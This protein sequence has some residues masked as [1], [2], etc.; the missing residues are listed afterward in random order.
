[1]GYNN[2]RNSAD[3]KLAALQAR[4]VKYKNRGEWI[5]IQGTWRGGRSFN[6]SVNA[7]SG[8]YK[9]FKTGETGSWPD[10]C[11]KLGMDPGTYSP[12]EKAE[13]AARKAE[14]DAQVAADK[15]RRERR[16]RE[17]MDPES[18][19]CRGLGR[20]LSALSGTMAAHFLTAAFDDEEYRR[21]K[22]GRRP[23]DYSRHLTPDEYRAGVNYL[24]SRGAL[25]FAAAAGALIGKGTAKA[26][27]GEG[28]ASPWEIRWPIENDVTDDVTGVQR[29]WARGH[30]G[31]KML[32]PKT[33]GLLVKRQNGGD[34]SGP[35]IIGEGMMTLRA[36]WLTFPDHHCWVRYDA[37]NMKAIAPDVIKGLAAKVIW[38]LVDNDLP[39]AEHP[40]RGETGQKASQALAEAIM[41]ARPDISVKLA[42]SPVPG[43]DWDD[44]ERR[45]KDEPAGVFQS[46]FLSALRDPQ[47][48]QPSGKPDDNDQAEPAAST[49]AEIIKPFE[50]FRQKPAEAV[51]LEPLETMTRAKAINGQ[52]R[53]VFAAITHLA[54]SEPESRKPAII[55][56]SVGT[57][58]TR[59]MNRAVAYHIGQGQ[60]AFLIATPRIEDRDAIAKDIFE[61]SG[62]KPHIH[63]ARNA[64]NCQKIKEVGELY[65]KHR[66]P[67]AWECQACPHGKADLKT[68]TEDRRCGYVKSLDA[69]L[70]ALGVI[71]THQAIQEDSKLFKKAIEY[72]THTAF[73]DRVVIL[74]EKVERTRKLAA[75][76]DDVVHVLNMNGPTLEHMDEQIAAAELWRDRAIAEENRDQI[77][78][79]KEHIETLIKGRDWIKEV[80]PEL[81]QIL[82]ALAKAARQKTKNGKTK[83][84]APPQA[85]NRATHPRLAELLGKIP[86]G[87]VA[88]DGTQLESVTTARTA[89]LA[90]PA[91]WLTSLG[92]A[93]NEGTAWILHGQIVGGHT[94]T[95]WTKALERGALLLDATPELR[96]V[97][98][99]HAAGGQTHDFIARTPNLKIKQVGPVLFGRGN[100]TAAEIARRVKIGTDW[101]DSAPLGVVAVMAH[102]KVAKKIIEARPDYAEFIGWWGKDEKAH[103]RWRACK[104]LIMI[105][106]PTQNADEARIEYAID[107]AA[108]APALAAAGYTMDVWN[109]EV[110]RKAWVEVD[111]GI[112]M[113]SA[114]PLPPANSF[115]RPWTLDKLA[116]SVTQFCGRLR[117]V[118]RPDEDLEAIIYTA[119]P[120]V[121]HGFRADEFYT[122]EGRVARQS[123]T[124]QAV[125]KAVVTSIDAGNSPT[126]RKVAELVKAE[127][128]RTPSSD[129]I[130]K[131]I[132]SIRRSALV[133]GVSFEAK[134][135]EVIEAVQQLRQAG[136]KP[137]AMVE[138]AIVSTG[139]AKTTW[140]ARARL[141][142]AL[143]TAAMADT[144]IA[145]RAG[146]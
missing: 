21:R 20:L 110:E 46:I 91:S 106:P 87:A 90:M 140:L 144:P 63:E 86:P 61:M 9:D 41:L 145:R 72:V 45:H 22:A 125:A 127:T 40:E 123:E 124:M 64:E 104:K 10:L 73:K 76:A 133:D 11:A 143:E 58:K 77:T 113:Q 70:G 30:H 37:S 137:A 4:G 5:D 112:E 126:R 98:D 42:L 19:D 120:I 18:T 107:Q 129:T 56:G 132:R 105:G 47:P 146:P 109:G 128:G 93:M 65:E 60:G 116:A 35:L 94:S 80:G 68:E 92:R 74:D 81:E 97:A 12:A 134:A 121:G 48:P 101:L 32:G 13:W 119:T 85:F 8:G 55:A 23:R 16:A 131:I 27:E 79:A 71:T 15:S 62:V 82:T 117:A 17:L 69:S 141:A 36:L 78:M 49:T 130:D 88:H 50:W 25:E 118:Q 26:F 67:Q 1:M 138:L 14:H 84:A 136:M 66:S 3:S 139:A 2:G 44:E 33:G 103:N 52:A 34:W 28:K 108:M 38:I 122:G 6:V 59:Q 54:E 7:F 102:K 31:K 29:E 95:L 114:L 135:A 83:R 115:A 57:G 39:N 53:A 99:V 43:E 100:L 75:K 142:R 111:G 51:S 96:A 24:A 89:R